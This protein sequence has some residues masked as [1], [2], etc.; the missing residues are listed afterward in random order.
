MYIVEE[1]ESLLMAQEAITEKNVKEQDSGPDEANL[2]TNLAASSNSSIGRQQRG[3]G[4]GN[5][6]NH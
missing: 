1:I 6:G 5:N 4:F 3:Y 2:A